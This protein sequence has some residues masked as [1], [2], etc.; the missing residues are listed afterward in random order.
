MYVF[1]SRDRAMQFGITWQACAS[2]KVEGSLGAKPALIVYAPGS[3]TRVREP[4]IE[5]CEWEDDGRGA[6]SGVEC[7]VL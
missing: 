4:I 7:A 6:M 2:G 1:L 5:D 3:M